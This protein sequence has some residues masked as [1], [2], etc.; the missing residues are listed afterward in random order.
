MHRCTC[1]AK[2]GVMEILGSVEPSSPNPRRNTSKEF[3]DVLRSGDIV[4]TC[5]KFVAELLPLSLIILNQAAT[6]LQR[7]AALQVPILN[8]R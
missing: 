8:G 2:R 4:A 1:I 7:V 5:C 6:N 3:F